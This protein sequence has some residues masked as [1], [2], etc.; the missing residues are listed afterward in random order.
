MAL[1]AIYKCQLLL[2]VLTLGGFPLMDE[3]EEDES[4]ADIRKLQ[5]LVT[6][7]G[8]SSD[9]YVDIDE[10]LQMENTTDVITL[11]KNNQN[12]QES[13]DEIVQYAEEEATIIT[14]SDAAKFIEKL[15]YYLLINKHTE[16]FDGLANLKIYLEYFYP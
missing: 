16:A 12:D 11:L 5:E 6:C 7:V 1:D 10:N 2:I 15:K 8:S 9:D 14:L 3:A 13:N 4:D